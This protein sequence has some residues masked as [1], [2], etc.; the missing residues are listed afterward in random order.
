VKAR[1]GDRSM[2]KL[3]RMDG[4][5]I[6]INCD[7]IAWLEACPDTTVRMLAG[8]TILVREG[9]DQVIA[10]IEDWRVRLLREAGLPA[11]ADA[12]SGRVPPAAL[13]GADRAGAARGGA[14]VPA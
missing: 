11:L 1:E 10:R 3:T 7:Q 6:A 14:E 13:P 2:I 8:E 12:A 9:L 5:E 4:K